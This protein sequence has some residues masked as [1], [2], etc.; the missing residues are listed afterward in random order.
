MS[1]VNF[2][3]EGAGA[4]IDAQG[5]RD[6]AKL[7]QRDAAAQRIAND[8]Q[9][10]LADNNAQLANWQA[11]DALYRAGMEVRNART[12]TRLLKGEQ[13]TAFAKSGVALDSGSVA[14]IL[15]DTDVL[16]EEDARMKEFNGEREAWAYR[17]QA[18]DSRN[19]AAILRAADV[20]VASDPDRAFVSS[21]VSS[22]ARSYAEEQRRK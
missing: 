21:I 15:T 4:F 16:G 7:Q 2:V 6:R 10:Q 1:W 14:N 18:L 19:R 12:N 9:A 5:S 13:R 3:I 17:M 22:A 8:A 11:A 20:P